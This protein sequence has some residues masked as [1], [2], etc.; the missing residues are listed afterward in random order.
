[1]VHIYQAKSLQGVVLLAHPDRQGFY[2]KSVVYVYSHGDGDTRGVIIN[3]PYPRAGR[4]LGYYGGRFAKHKHIHLHT[5]NRG[6]AT[7]TVLAQNE[8]SPTDRGRVFQGYICWEAQELTNEVM[9]NKWF[10]SKMAIV[11]VLEIPSERV[12]SDA[13]K[14]HPWIHSLVYVNS[15][16][17]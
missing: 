7:W 1:M 4:I 9:E 5:N 10:I 16:E 12:Y 13:M 6:R 11:E 17:A 3:H 15:G 8:R 2:S 14:N